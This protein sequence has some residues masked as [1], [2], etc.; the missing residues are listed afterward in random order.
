MSR[1]A[2]GIFGEQIK[3]VTTENAISFLG[4]QDARVLATPWM[5]GYMEMTAR[6]AVKPHLSDTEDT[7]GTHVDVR[8]VAAAPIG[9]KVQ[10]QAVV[11]GIEGRRVTFRV[12]ARTVAAEPETIGE[13]TH[14]RAV[15]DVKRFAEKL[16]TKRD[17]TQA[18]SAER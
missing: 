18:G 10:F 7:V 8:H 4:D 1:L 16:R 11:T 17:G 3:D 5:I 13:G 12:T 15:I 9:A 2:T 6:D 14:E